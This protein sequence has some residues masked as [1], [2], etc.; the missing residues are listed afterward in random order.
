[1]PTEKKQIS[2]SFSCKRCGT[3]CREEG[4]V[5]FSKADISRASKLLDMPQ[6]DF[7]LRYLVFSSDGYFH[8]VT[9]RKACA[10]LKNNSCIINEVKPRQ[11]STFPFWKEYMSKDGTI[12]RFDRPCP[13]MKKKV[14]SRR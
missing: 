3:C 4:V 10:F 9:K 12:V 5:Y 11:C 13:G 6:K 7:I 14:I 1:M 8:T 2:Y